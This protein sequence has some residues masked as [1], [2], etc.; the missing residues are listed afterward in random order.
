MWTKVI[1]P[2]LTIPAVRRPVRIAPGERWCRTCGSELPA[3]TNFGA[4]GSDGEDKG[5]F[6]CGSE[7]LVPATD[8]LHPDEYYIAA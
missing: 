7:D 1:L 3:I 2:P 6:F 5:C 4:D 8:I